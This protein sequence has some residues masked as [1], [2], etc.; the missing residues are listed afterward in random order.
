MRRRS[1]RNNAVVRSV[2]RL[3]A[4]F[5]SSV[6]GELDPVVIGQ[7]LLAV[8]GVVVMT[9]VPLLGPSRRSWIVLIAVG[10]V[11]AAALVVSGFI[12]WSL[13]PRYATLLFPALVAVALVTISVGSPGLV[14]PLTGV[15][16]FCFAFIGLTQPPGVSLLAAPV[17]GATLIVA[18]AG[19]SR[20]VGV[21][22]VI[23]LMVWV[24]LAELLARLAR[25]Q[26]ELSTALRLA[27]HTDAL[28]GVANRRHLELHLTT[29]GSGD[30]IVICDLDHFKRL[31]D[32]HGYHAG[33]RV[34]AH[35]GRC[36]PC[37]GRTTTPR[38]TTGR[39]S[40]SC[41]L[42]LTATR[43]AVCSIECGPPGPPGDPTSPSRPASP[44]A[45][46]GARTPN[47]LSRRM[48]LSTRP[49]RPD[50]PPTDQNC[51]DVHAGS[52]RAPAPSAVRSELASSARPR[53]PPGTRRCAM[54]D[55]GVTL[56]TGVALAGMGIEELY[57][58][59]VALTGVLS[60]H[61]LGAVVDEEWF[62]PPTLEWNIAAHAINER[63][64][65]IGLPYAVGYL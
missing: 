40:S 44:T 36:G 15:L 7:V 10:G 61:E 59:Y 37:C 8:A 46:P 56:R 42:R 21:R 63:L 65:E 18:N 23:A 45:D 24:L 35:F 55:S 6:S 64:N 47:P 16:T 34:L 26:T 14:A 5:D 2:R 12:R 25:R 3:I 41:S 33:D 4:G 50:S 43:P 53:R 27:A 22:L 60:Y 62:A 32:T 11:M 52:L 1:D 20:P 48:P 9:S 30:A 17:A 58:R 31:N 28:T 57:V 39:S 29:V 19:W 38:A 49:R 51:D 54:S 13:L